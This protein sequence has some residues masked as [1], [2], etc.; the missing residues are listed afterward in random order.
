MLLTVYEQRAFAI[1]R[2]QRP[3]SISA[4]GE[5]AS[6]ILNATTLMHE[7]GHLYGLR[8]HGNQHEPKY[9]PFYKSVMSYSYSSFGIPADDPV[10]AYREDRLDPAGAR[11]QSHE[12]DAA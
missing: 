2:A 8:H 11:L 10:E 12:L 1:M 7:L 9:D 4:R 5:L 6:D 3:T